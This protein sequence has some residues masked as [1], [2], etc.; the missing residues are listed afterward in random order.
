MS[1]QEQGRSGAVAIV[2][3]ERVE[4]ML[5]LGHELRHDDFFSGEPGN[6]SF[7]EEIVEGTLLAAQREHEERKL[8][9]LGNLLASFAFHEEIS[10]GGANFLLKLADDLS[11]RQLCLLALADRKDEFPSL[12]DGTFEEL[13]KSLEQGNAPENAVELFTILEEAEGLTN[14]GML[15]QRVQIFMGHGVGFNPAQVQPQRWGGV[16]NSL[17]ALHEMPTTELEPLAKILS[18]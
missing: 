18:S 17:M 11:Y 4:K 2:A 14:L 16:L 7:A 9:Y 5:R 10:R 13:E 6:R 3:T 8:L 15:G 1:R 12:R